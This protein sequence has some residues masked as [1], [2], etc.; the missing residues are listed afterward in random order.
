MVRVKVEDFLPPLGAVVPA[1][2]VGQQGDDGV[3]QVGWFATGVAGVA[4]AA[5]WA[6]GQYGLAGQGAV[7][8]EVGEVVQAPL[9]AEHEQYVAAD[10][11]FAAEQHQAVG[12][13]D[14]RGAV[15]GEDVD[16]LVGA[17]AAPGFEPEALRVPVTRAGALYRHLQP[18]RG[19]QPGQQ[20]SDEQV[21]FT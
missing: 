12:R 21:A 13:G 2:G 14:D 17:G 18:L 3:V 4:D 6:A 15:A 8:G 7:V 19:E 1:P 9:G 11:E 20:H 10:A 5:E 16:A